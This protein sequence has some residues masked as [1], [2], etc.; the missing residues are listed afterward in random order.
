MRVLFLFLDGVGLGKADPETNPFARAHL[1]ALHGMLGGRRLL[2]ENV[3]LETSRASLLA[4]DAGL[5]VAGLPQSASGQAV[6]LTGRNVPAEIGLHYGPKPNP[7]IA[8][9]L[10]QGNLFQDLKKTGRSAGL[11]NAYPDGYFHGI[12]SG[13]RLLSA[14][15]LAVTSAGL[16]LL[17]QADLHAGRALSADFTGEAWRERLSDPD[18]PVF[19]PH[20]AGQNLA[21]LAERYDFAFFEYWLS[22][23]AG[24]KQNMDEAVPLLET[25][26]QVLAGLLSAWDD[27]AGLIL[28]TSD[29]GNLEDLSTRKHTANAV[30]GLV[31]GSPALRRP[32][33]E[34]LSTLADIAPAIRRFLQL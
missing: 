16:P 12:E 33:A 30:P 9:I 28:M 1:P 5:G 6:L 15:P 22:D 11:L 34:G 17:R 20:E 21:R 19:S 14:I 29:H 27:E 18:C 8:A 32:F 3:P 13:H 31:V 24:H 10:R 7:P 4:L 2:A 23:Y 26:D 25:F